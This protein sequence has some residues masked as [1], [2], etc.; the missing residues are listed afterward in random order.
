MTKKVFTPELSVRASGEGFVSVVNADGTAT[1]V[2]PVIKNTVTREVLWALSQIK[3]NFKSATSYMD[4]FC[5]CFDY[6]RLGDGNSLMNLQP[7]S[8]TYVGE[9]GKDI[10][11][12]TTIGMRTLDNP[13]TGYQDQY[14][15]NTGYC[16]TDDCLTGGVYTIKLRRSFR[17]NMTSG[18]DK[19]ILREVGLYS[20]NTRSYQPNY[21]VSEG[22]TTV[23]TPTAIY[24]GCCPKGV[25]MTARLVLPQ[26]LKVD[27]KQAIV[28]TYDFVISFN[29]AAQ[30]QII[31][32][33]NARTGAVTGELPC[34][35][36]YGTPMARTAFAG[37]RTF[38]ATTT[39]DTD[40]ISGPLPYTVNASGG[41]VT[42]DYGN[43]NN[44]GFL[45]PAN[46]NNSGNYCATYVKGSPETN[47]PVF[48]DTQNIGATAAGTE[49]SSVTFNSWDINYSNFE[50]IFH[51]SSYLPYQDATA[52][53]TYPYEFNIAG[54]R[55]WLQSVYD[56][57][58]GQW[59]SPVER[60][61]SMQYYLEVDV[62]IAFD[63]FTIP[64]LTYDFENSAWINTAKVPR[65]LDRDL[66]IEEFG[67]TLETIP[68]HVYVDREGAIGDLD[69]S[70]MVAIADSSKLVSSVMTTIPEGLTGFYRRP[71]A[72][73][74]KVYMVRYNGAETTSTDIKWRLWVPW[75]GLEPYAREI[76]GSVFGET[77]ATI[78]AKLFSDFA[79]TTPYT[80]TPADGTIAYYKREWTSEDYLYNVEYKNVGGS[81]RWW[82]NDNMP[83]GGSTIANDGTS[84]IDFF[85]SEP[86]FEGW[87]EGAYAMEYQRGYM[88][89]FYYGTDGE[90][91]DCYRVNYVRSNLNANTSADAKPDDKF[92]WIIAEY[93]RRFYVEKDALGNYYGPTEG[94]VQKRMPVP[95]GTNYSDNG[96]IDTMTP[97]A[98]FTGFGGF[99]QYS[100]NKAGMSKY[101]YQFTQG[102]YYSLY[103]MCNVTGSASDPGWDSNWDG[104]AT[105]YKP[106]RKGIAPEGWHMPSIDE[107]D[108]MYMGSDFRCNTFNDS[109]SWIAINPFVSLQYNAA[110]SYF[111]WDLEFPGT[112]NG[113]ASWYF[114]DYYWSWWSTSRW[115]RTGVDLGYVGRSQ[116]D[117]RDR[118]S[119]LAFKNL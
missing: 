71:G 70:T 24:N 20:N 61:P 9:Q 110:R 99:L 28:V 53:T 51:F 102:R 50:M 114:R 8:D 19:F 7:Y 38:G 47:Q 74:T 94:G 43:Y 84:Y 100:G 62:K 57:S 36:G 63:N 12:P 35:L 2:T 21:I 77:S 85:A 3:A 107:Y 118:M 44:R 104:D 42:G 79:C 64:D 87:D 97:D 55:L 45:S 82:L 88:R 27:L 117:A 16:G 119:T 11:Y 116:S 76:L 14:F 29:V 4:G 6:A 22:T 72:T 32:L 37:Y 54:I 52:A 39:A 33:R 60:R 91:K 73:K 30:D 68:D 112:C 26:P 69:A 17:F 65:L 40:L 90:H 75:T 92:G 80:E 105:K 81:L 108:A 23:P 111:R 106:G 113:S 103:E 18:V 95:V 56:E 78:G 34:K 67:E 96:S 93:Y 115:Y 31:Q 10:T 58:K 89:D 46:I 83:I 5:R 66:L 86:A 109:E 101:N 98:Y 15:T 59:V 13:T 1:Q 49:I 25:G 41:V 48:Q